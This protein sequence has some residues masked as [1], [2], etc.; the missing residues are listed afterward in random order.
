MEPF[1]GGDSIFFFS[2]FFLFFLFPVV[3]SSRSPVGHRKKRRRRDTGPRPLPSTGPTSSL[4]RS[5]IRQR[6]HH[7]PITP[8]H[9][10]A[11]VSTLDGCSRDRHI[12]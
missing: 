12:S 2:F 3:E 6:L 8:T 11:P 9:R 5:K 1:G 4:G 10:Q 7:L